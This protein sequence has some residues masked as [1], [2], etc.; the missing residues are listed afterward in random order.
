MLA[1]AVVSLLG[2][3][4]LQQVFG[5][6]AQGSD[7]QRLEASLVELKEQQRALELEGADVRSL[8]SVQQRVRELNLV[9]VDRVAYLAPMPGHVA[10]LPR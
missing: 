7:I 5:T 6:A 4:Y 1:L 2:F 8:Q 3:F 10:R 9:D